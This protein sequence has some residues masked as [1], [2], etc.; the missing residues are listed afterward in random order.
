[1]PLQQEELRDVQRRLTQLVMASIDTFG[2]L[3]A[4][5]DWLFGERAP[6]LRAA[7]DEWLK[8]FVTKTE[9]SGE[10]HPEAAIYGTEG[11]KLQR[12]GLYGAQLAVKEQQLTAAN[13]G[14]LDGLGRRLRSVVRAPFRRWVDVL[15]NF[16]GS[17]AGAT[18][19]GEAL[20]E[21]KDCLRDALPEE[22]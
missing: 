12:A 17:L 6:Q 8:D 1:M 21:L 22:D 11:D 13:R 19:W 5:A 16:L 4:D 2:Q 14:L 9:L 20:K 10:R 7:I 18:G 3:S 15:N